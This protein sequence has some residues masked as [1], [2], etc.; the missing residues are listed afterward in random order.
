MRHPPLEI[1]EVRVQLNQREHGR[2]RAFCS[3]TFAD[4]FVV[5]DLK[6]IASD[7][8]EF[9]AMPSRK[10]ADRCGHCGEKNPLRARFCNQCGAELDP[11][12][13][14][15]GQEGRARLHADLA[16][17]INRDCRRRLEA[18][19]LEAYHNEVED[20]RQDGYVPKHL[21]EFEEEDGL[22][23]ESDGGVEAGGEASA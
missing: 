10:L 6:V 3:V 14:T 1:S 9:V 8:G 22:H 4:Q 17:P 11:A 18:A 5:R 21:D 2:V 23:F 13:A 7:Q 20:S 15:A 19:I 12:R 16:H